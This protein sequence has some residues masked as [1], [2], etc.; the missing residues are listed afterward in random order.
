LITAVLSGRITVIRTIVRDLLTVMIAEYNL[1]VAR[2]DWI[3]HVRTSMK[4][5]A[6]V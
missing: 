3:Y 4:H 6:Y 2:Q 1:P 5:N